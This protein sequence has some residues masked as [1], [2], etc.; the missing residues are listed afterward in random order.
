MIP[1]SDRVAKRLK[2]K[3]SPL[4][5]RRHK[6]EKCGAVFHCIQ[7]ENAMLRAKYVTRKKRYNFDRLYSGIHANSPF[8]CAGCLAKN[9]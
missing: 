3:N 8:V 1:N 7:C 2:R 4:L 9:V 5:M 6:C